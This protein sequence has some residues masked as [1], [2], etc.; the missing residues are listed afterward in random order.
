MER[1]K[2]IALILLFLAVA[3]GIGFMLYRL[4]FL[5]P[6][7]KGAAPEQGVT[8]REPVSGLPSSG[9]FVPG[10]GLA[11]GE[12]PSEVLVPAEEADRIASGGLTRAESLESARTLS[13]TL[14]PTG[15]LSFYDEND[16]HFYTI[17]EN[18][19]RR[20]LSNKKFFGAKK[21]TW[22]PST[23]KAIIEFPDASK[24]IY[25]FESEQQVTL[26]NHWEDF[27][28][29]SDGETFA[30]KA[31]GRDP[32]NQWLITVDSDGSNAKL[33]EHLGNNAD[34]VTVS[35]SPDN[36][37]VALA[38][39]G[40]PV[41]FDTREV[42]LIGQNNENYKALRIDGFNFK[43]VW[44]PT[45]EHLLYS[46]ASGASDYKPLLWFVSARGDAIGKNRTNLGLNTWASKCTFAD[47][48]TVYCAVPDDLPAGIGLQPDLN[49][50][51]SDSIYRIDLKQGKTTLVG[52][53]E[54]DLNIK[55]LVV[56]KDLRTLYMQSSASGGLSQ[57]RLK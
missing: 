18:G 47:P 23:D 53:P 6:S 36:A 32:E 25:D 20:R 31:L 13:P 44:S 56:S 3:S 12:A 15:S 4:F 5:T 39:T 21:V 19:N 8:T 54:G 49:E 10:E 45:G 16:G 51:G 9:E 7:D 24:V 2:K 17:D 37:V 34:K 46:A 1:I 55:T 29:A 27:S 26:P 11:P 22:A 52:K 50:G 14:S 38:Q 41:G 57:M 48:S 40:D 30:A 35:V 43:P 33:V 28:F 42:I